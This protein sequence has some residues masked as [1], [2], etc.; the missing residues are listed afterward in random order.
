[1]ASTNFEF[2][3]K[4][5]TL[6][7]GNENVTL[8]IGV[9]TDGQYLYIADFSNG[10]VLKWSASGGAFVALN[11]D[12]FTGPFDVV[13]WQDRLFVTDFTDNDITVLDPR[14]LSLVKTLSIS[15]SSPSGMAVGEEFLY[16]G[17]QGNDRINKIDRALTSVATLTSITNPEHLAYDDH[18]KALYISSASADTVLKYNT[19]D[20]STLLDT[21]SSL[22][23]PRGLAVKDHYLYVVEDNKV[24]A[25]DTAS[26]VARATAGTAGSGNTNISTGR[27]LTTDGDVLFF[28]DAGLSRV[29]VWADYKAERAFSS[30]DSVKVGGAI[31]QNPWQVIG[32]TVEGSAPT[33]GGTA[34]SDLAN[35]VEEIPLL[36]CAANIEE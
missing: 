13:L 20:F 21:I 10:R 19:K 29:T 26:L 36:D 3:A 8:P 9:T 25:Y 27:G 32:E 22:D 7:T 33:I 17:E 15:V 11:T 1:M 12:D 35:N 28:I 16:V 2:I 5:G 18:E 24:T 34:I 6:G 30:G 4:F 23:D 14:D 31:G